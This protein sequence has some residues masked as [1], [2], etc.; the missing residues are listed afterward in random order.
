MTDVSIFTRIMNGEIPSDKVYE[1]DDC[2]CIKDISPKA[3]VHL[4]LIPRKQIPRLVDATAE[5]Q[6]L[7]GQLMIKAG[8]IA[9]ENGVG[10][11]FRLI[12]NNGEEAGQ[13]VFHLHLHI[14]GGKQFTESQL[15]F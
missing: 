1:D 8:D 11:A 13:T 4:L 3:P 12:V 2:I 10:D 15:G 14:L 6:A 9:R 7:L 5:D